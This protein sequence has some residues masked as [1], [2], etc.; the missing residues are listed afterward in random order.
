MSKPKPKNLVLEVL[1]EIR[2]ELR[3]TRQE[4]SSRL[5][6]TREELSGRI[7]AT[8]AELSSGIGA[9]NAAML[10][11][12]Q[13][14]RFIVAHFRALTERDHRFDAE[15]TELRVRVAALESREPR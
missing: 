5:D 8:R 10:E 1:R 13:Q 15:L 6:A 12:A 3:T 2:E 11:L 14:Q 9:T 7:D 4:L